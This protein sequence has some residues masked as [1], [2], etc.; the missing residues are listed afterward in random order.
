ML[1]AAPR[2]FC[3]ERFRPRFLTECQLSVQLHVQADSGM[4]GEEASKLQISAPDSEFQT[5]AGPYSNGWLVNEELGCKCR[6]VSSQYFFVLGHGS[7]TKP[8]TQSEIA[9]KVSRANNLALFGRAVLA[10]KLNTSS[11]SVRAG[12]IPPHRAT[13]C[14]V[15]LP[16][17]GQA[18]PIRLALPPLPDARRGVSLHHVPAHISRTPLGVVPGKPRHGVFADGAL[19]RAFRVVRG[20]AFRTSIRRNSNIAQ[21]DRIVSQRIR[22]IHF[23][24]PCVC[25]AKNARAGAVLSVGIIGRLST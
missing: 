12:L 2:Q 23:V 20:K 17:A 18:T 14:P 9:K 1:C 25:R 3:E 24:R 16:E 13:A 5:A 15:P 22:S 7:T 19:N 6:H 4:P 8:V 10:S 21:P 11:T